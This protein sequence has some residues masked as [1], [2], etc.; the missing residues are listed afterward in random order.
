VTPHHSPE[1]DEDRLEDTDPHTT[2]I[3][4]QTTGQTHIRHPAHIGTYGRIRS[5]RCVV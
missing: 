4:D 1:S 3:D 2:R 5:R